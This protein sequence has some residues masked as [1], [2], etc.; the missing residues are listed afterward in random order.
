MVLT[1]TTFF[2]LEVG[3]RIFSPFCLTAESRHLKR[4]YTDE[5][6]L[7]WLFCCCQS[8]YSRASVFDGLV[9]GR[10]GWIACHRVICQYIICQ[11]IIWVSLWRNNYMLHGCIHNELNEIQISCTKP[12]QSSCKS[13]LIEKISLISGWSSCARAGALHQKFSK[14]SHC[15]TKR[16][17]KLLY[18]QY[19]LTLA[20]PLHCSTGCN[21]SR[22]SEPLFPTCP[23]LLSVI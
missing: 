16:A 10:E 17:P 2:P 4:N 13:K 12:E 21:T 7:M 6:E 14:W 18:W 9:K 20:I 3:R 22:S 5:K 11:H 1:Q 15:R 23:C 8:A 19:S